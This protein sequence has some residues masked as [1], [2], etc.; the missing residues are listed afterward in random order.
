MN[1]ESSIST[2]CKL[3]SLRNKIIAANESAQFLN[4]QEDN[5]PNK[6]LF[7]A[8]M[9]STRGANVSAHKPFFILAYMR[10]LEGLSL[11]TFLYS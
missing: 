5:L 10:F 1:R 9:S 7:P 11:K 4:F 2:Q 8:V 6:N 3:F